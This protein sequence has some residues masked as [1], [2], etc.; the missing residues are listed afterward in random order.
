[1]C[2]VSVRNGPNNIFGALQKGKYPRFDEAVH[3]PVVIGRKIRVAAYGDPAAIPISDWKKILK[4]WTGGHIG[5]A[6]AWAT[7]DPDY[8]SYFMASV[9]SLKGAKAA[10]MAGWRYFRIMKPGEEFIHNKEDFLSCC[11]WREKDQMRVVHVMQ[12]S[13][14][15]T[16]TRLRSDASTWWRRH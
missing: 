11:A 12:W 4:C 10:R 14:R 16:E 6:H 5:Y 3:A 13:R 7:V 9:V 8:R 2:Y 1:M 15:K